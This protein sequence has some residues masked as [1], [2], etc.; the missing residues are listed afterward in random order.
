MSRFF[1]KAAQTHE[2]P[3]RSKDY[4]YSK[5]KPRRKRAKPDPRLR[6]YGITAKELQKRVR[7]QKGNCVICG[8]SAKLVIDHCHK[9]TKFRELLCGKCNTILGLANDD[10]AILVSAANYLNK[11]HKLLQET[12]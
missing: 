1:K 9:T 5:R 12:S 6:K 11:W 7:N 10:P 3:R 4:K 2:I 8:K